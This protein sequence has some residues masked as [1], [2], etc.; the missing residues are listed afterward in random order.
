MNIFIGGPRAVKILENAVKSRLDGIVDKG[1]QV[2][3]GDADGVDA[4]VQEYLAGKNYGHVTVYASNGR[5]RNNAGGWA[6]RNIVAPRNSKGFNFYAAKDYA[7]AEDSDYGF[8]IWNGVSRG[9]QNNIKNLLALNKRVLLYF[10]PTQVF[11]VV[12]SFE[13]IKRL[14]G[15]SPHSLSL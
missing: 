13:D 6:I 14:S 9:T 8:M 12:K 2:L 1:F 15:Q 4:C 11:I 7:M 3:V 5:A 10:A